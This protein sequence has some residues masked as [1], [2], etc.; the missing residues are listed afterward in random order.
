MDVSENGDAEKSKEESDKE[1][2]KTEEPVKKK[3]EDD[4]GDD[5]E[6]PCKSY[7]LCI[8]DI[9]ILNFFIY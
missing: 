2:S 3:E 9:I 7:E 4:E 6:P 8:I 1:D 5:E